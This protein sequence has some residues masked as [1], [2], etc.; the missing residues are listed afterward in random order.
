MGFDGNG[1]PK[2]QLV[3]EQKQTD[4]HVFAFMS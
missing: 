4:V 3:Q 2:I 1:K